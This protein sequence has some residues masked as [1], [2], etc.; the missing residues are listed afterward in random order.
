[1]KVLAPSLRQG[2]S[3]I[4]ILSAMALFSVLAIIIAQTTSSISRTTNLSNRAIDA[5]SQSRVAFD[6]I[7]LDLAALIKRTDVD[8]CSQNI[9]TTKNSLMFFSSVTSAG[10][11]SA[12]NR[13]ISLVAYRV[14]RHADNQNRPC[15]VRAGKAVEWSAADLMGLQPNNGL[16]LSFDSFT[17]SSDSPSL[18]ALLP[19]TSDF[20]VLAPGVIRMVVGYQLYPD[21]KQ[22]TVSGSKVIAMGQIVYSPPIR[23][24]TPTNGGASVDYVDL[25]RISA[26]VVGLVAVDNNS[27]RPLSSTQITD[28]ANAFATPSDGKLPSRTWVPLSN[29]PTLMPSSVP[30]AI[31][32][33]VRIFE[34]CYPIN[35]YP[36]PGL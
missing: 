3:L 4:E 7:G 28:L 2:F 12:S 20:D 17:L 32:Q 6:R 1:M 25:S 19:T 9:D 23:T 10:L 26:L 33:A 14:S 24:L 11:T 27:L 15:L 29:D 30:L 22:V 35:P 36:A 16:P 21:H 13:G 18:Y 8:F 5:A 34:R 31:R